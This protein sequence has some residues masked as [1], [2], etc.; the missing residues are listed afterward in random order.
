MSKGLANLATKKRLRVIGLMSGTSADGIDAAVVD[1]S[2]ARIQPIAFRTFVYRPAVRKEIFQLFRPETCQLDRLCHMNFLLGELFADAVLRLCRHA[3]IDVKSV[4]LIGSH[5]QT[6]YHIPQP[7]VLGSPKPLRSTLQIGEPSVIAERTGVTTVADFRPRDIA[8]G[9]EG[10]PLVPLTDW[11]LFRHAGKARALQNIGGIANVTFLPAG[12][13]PQDTLAFDTG[14]G[15]M[16]IDRITW[17]VTGGA[18][19]FDAGGSLAARGQVDQTLLKELMQ[20]A[21]F[22]RKP[23]K[24]TGREMFGAQVADELW[25][26][27]RARRIHK[28]DLL[29]TAT[30]FTACSIADAYKRFLPALPQE[31]ILCGGGARNEHLRRLLA[32]SLAPS[33]VL[34]MDE[35]GINADAKEAISFA[36]LAWQSIR[37]E[38]GNVCS[39][40]GASHPAVLGK[41]VPA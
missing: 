25:K 37:G 7:R 22:R 35:L 5:G 12:G 26:A 28:L 40:T 9:G 29:A 6:I 14:P 17:H 41:I 21:Y 34:V 1:I 15:N 2:A 11:M 8:A 18:K 38:C 36:L 31:T 13:G 3:R 4:D 27:A 16:L 19:S 20:H 23:P 10:A 33:R 24:S 32:E 39:A 30:A